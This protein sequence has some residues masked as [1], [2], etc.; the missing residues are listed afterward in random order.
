ML[1]LLSNLNIFSLMDKKN[2]SYSTRELNELAE[3][4]LDV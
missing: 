4:S 1:Q 3:G 2:D